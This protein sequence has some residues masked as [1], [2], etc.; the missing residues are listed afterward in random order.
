MQ[1][2]GQSDRQRHPGS[3]GGS[4]DPSRVFKGLRMAG[5]M[6]NKRATLRNVEVVE[7]IPEKNLLL[8]KGGLPGAN[9]SFLEIDMV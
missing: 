1:T 7:V 9:N 5:Q 4:S 3:I 8:V 6:G 2:H